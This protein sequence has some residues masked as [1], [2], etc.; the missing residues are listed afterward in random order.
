MKLHLELE[1]IA[2]PSVGGWQ[3]Y[4]IGRRRAFV[5]FEVPAWTW[6]LRLLRKVERHERQGARA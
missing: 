6:L 1:K 4:R 2:N 3:T 5:V